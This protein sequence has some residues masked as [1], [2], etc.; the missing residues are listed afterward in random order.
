M[1]EVGNASDFKLR[2]AL[3][4]AI[5]NNHLETVCALIKKTKSIITS[6]TQKWLNNRIYDAAFEE[7]EKEIQLLERAGVKTSEI[8]QKARRDRERIKREKR[9]RMFN[10]N[11]HVADINAAYGIRDRINHIRRNGGN[12]DNG[13]YVSKQQYFCQAK[14]VGLVA[15]RKKPDD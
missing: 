15:A 5:N 10:S 13:G 12:T 4:C 2:K 6:D 1:L 7:K 3:E 9:E 14:Y 8:V 11:T